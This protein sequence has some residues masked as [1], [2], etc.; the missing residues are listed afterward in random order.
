MT[1]FETQ[2]KEYFNA[3]TNG[4]FSQ[5]NDGDVIVRD[6][7][8]VLIKTYQQQL[9]DAAAQHE[10]EAFE[11]VDDGDHLDRL[12]TNCFTALPNR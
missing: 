10:A 5:W 1:P 6:A 3:I 9:D 12:L 2:L 11:E 8:N 4:E 7:A